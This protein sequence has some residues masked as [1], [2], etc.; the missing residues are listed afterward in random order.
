MAHFG[1]SDLCIGIGEKSHVL[2]SEGCVSGWLF[3]AERNY[4]PVTS[5]WLP[6]AGQE[7]KDLQITP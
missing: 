1:T 3:P 7:A 5:T 2:Q 6:P 4:F